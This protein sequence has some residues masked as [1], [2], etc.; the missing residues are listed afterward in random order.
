MS[1][2]W[3][4][5]FFIV[6]MFLAA[7]NSKALGLCIVFSLG[8]VCLYPNVIYASLLTAFLIP[9]YIVATFRD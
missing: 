2:F 5:G 6:A 1:E 4:P 3:F 7:I 8:L 9:F